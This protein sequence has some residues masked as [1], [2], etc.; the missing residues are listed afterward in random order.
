MIIK[1]P[2]TAIDNKFQELEQNVKIKWYVLL[3]IGFFFKQ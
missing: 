3:L 1:L 2:K